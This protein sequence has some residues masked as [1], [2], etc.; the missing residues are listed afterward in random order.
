MPDPY[1]EAGLEP[2]MSFDSANTA[3]AVHPARWM[4]HALFAAGVYHLLWGLTV[5]IFPDQACHWLGMHP[6]NYS[7]I[8]QYVGGVT[9]LYGVAFLLAAINP[10][11]HWLTVLLG[12]FSKL[13]GPACFA[14]GASVGK[15]PM[16]FGWTVI[17]NDLIWWV[18]FCLILLASYRYYSSG[19]STVVPEI[20]EFALRA[21]TNTG[22]SV[23]E[24]SRKK[25]V[26]LV[27]LRHFGCPFCREVMDDVSAQLKRLERSDVQLVLIH[28][29]D[30]PLAEQF[31]NKYGLANIPHVSDTKRVLYRAFGLRRG[32]F[33]QM[34]SPLLWWRG[35]RA[36]LAHGQGFSPAYG[37]VLQMPGM[38]LIFHGH[39]VRSF[40]HQLAGDR[41]N[42]V[43]FATST[44]AEP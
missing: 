1:D 20:Q 6:V 4:V 36:T 22:T 37:S 29:S 25:P 38:F 8:W 27:F 39:V 7:P 14:Y 9:A 35:L 43:A 26:L 32:T 5:V 2:S 41:P 40:I 28:M 24:M 18:P 17:T 10:F 30:D 44:D 12:L 21:R 3:G 31:L 19:A 34:A 15:L 13:L 23:L 42:Y 11:Q 16:Q 33:W